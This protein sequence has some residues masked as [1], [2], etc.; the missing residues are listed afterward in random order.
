L[1]MTHFLQR[2]YLVSLFLGKLLVG[3]HK[4]SPTRLGHAFDLAVGEA[5]ILPQLTSLSAI[6]VALGS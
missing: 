3:S 5:L 1:I 2:I 4:C 6:K